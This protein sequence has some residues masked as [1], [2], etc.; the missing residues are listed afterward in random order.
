MSTMRKIP[1][2][3]DRIKALEVRRNTVMGE[4]RRRSTMQTLGANNEFNCNKK[5]HRNATTI[6]GNVEQIYS[7]NGIKTNEGYEMSSEDENK[8][9]RNSVR[10]QTQSPP[11]VTTATW[12]DTVDVRNSQM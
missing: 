10:M 5:Q 7:S 2:R 1:M 4:A 8:S 3:R 9:T 6:T 12:K 11:T